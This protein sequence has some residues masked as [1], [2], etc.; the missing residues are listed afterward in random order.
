MVLIFLKASNIDGAYNLNENALEIY[1]SWCV[2]IS[3][4]CDLTLYTSNQLGVYV[5]RWKKYFILMFYSL[6]IAIFQ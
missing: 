4:Q 5:F 3:M 6:M 2:S 1:I